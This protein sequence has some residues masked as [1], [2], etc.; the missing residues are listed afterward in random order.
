MTEYNV[1][2]DESCHLENDGHSSMVLGAIWC[3]NSERHT[4]F[5]HIKE[6]KAKH[7]LYSSFEIKWNKISPSKLNFYEELVNYF[8]DHDQLNFRALVIPDKNVLAHEQYGQTHDEFYYKIYFDM[9]KIIISPRNI[10]NIFLDI[11]DTQGYEKIQKLREVIHNEKYDFEEKIINK[12][13]EVRSEEVNILQLTD[14]FIGAMAYYYRQLKGNRAKEELIELIK[15]RSG[16]SLNQ[17]T[18]P[19]EPKFNFFIWQTGYQRK[20]ADGSI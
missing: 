5:Q 14:L 1:Y 18:L 4:I 20:R 3:K 2:C 17:S 8:F 11:K 16:Y 15:K 9:L 13:Q 12:I 6:I 19:T 7:K 10:Y